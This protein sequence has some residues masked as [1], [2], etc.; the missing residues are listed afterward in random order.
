MKILT[1]L[2]ATLLLGSIVTTANAKDKAKP[3]KVLRHVVLFMF[4]TA[5]TEKQV[6]EVVDAFAA[7]P[8][9]IDTIIDFEMGTDVS[10]EKLSAGY[11]HGF[12]VTFADEKGR[13]IYLP[14][15]KHKEFVTLVKPVI[16]G[17]LVF[18]YWATR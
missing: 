18:D 4:K 7:L 5:A 1:M 3:K 13:E 2:L 15:P 17:V 6:K 12:V 8:S 11:T 16:D 9:K 10:V 14:H